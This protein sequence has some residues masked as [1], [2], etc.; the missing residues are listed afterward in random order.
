[1]QNWDRPAACQNGIS[2]PPNP[3]SS[4]AVGAA[5]EAQTER[6]NL[7]TKHLSSLPS[8]PPA[9]P[10]TTSNIIRHLVLV[11]GS[12]NGRADGEINRSVEEEDAI[13]IQHGSKYKQTIFILW[14]DG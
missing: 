7:I 4:S 10:V 13:R 6:Q 2:A 1:M 11:A 9:P 3:Q 8:L 5:L 14:K 12:K